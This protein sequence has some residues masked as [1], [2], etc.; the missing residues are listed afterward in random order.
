MRLDPEE[1]NAIAG[2]LADALAPLLIPRIV[3]AIREQQ[4]A[5]PTDAEGRFLDAPNMAR[6][7][8]ISENTLRNRERAGAIPSVRNGRRVLFDPV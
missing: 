7:I 2:A 6:Q 3:D 4:E 5:R 1:L 8:G